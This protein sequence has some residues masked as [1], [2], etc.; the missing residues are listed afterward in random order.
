MNRQ[1]I[2][3]YVHSEKIRFREDKSNKSNKYLRNQIRNQLIPIILSMNPSFSK[4]FIKERL[5]LQQIYKVYR[6]KVAESLENIIRNHKTHITIDIKF[7]KEGESM[8][9]IAKASNGYL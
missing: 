2:E 6:I 3:R 8:F 1:D 7:L 4:T 5:I 9:N